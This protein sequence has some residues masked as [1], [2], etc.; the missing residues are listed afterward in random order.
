[1]AG[2]DKAGV[3]VGE[4]G[5]DDDMDMSLAEALRPT[6]RSGSP[7]PLEGMA[8]SGH[9]KYN[10]S[11]SLRS[12]PKVCTVLRLFKAFM[13]AIVTDEPL[14]QDAKCLLSKAHTSHAYT[15]SHADAFPIVIFLELYPSFQRAAWTGATGQI[16]IAYPSSRGF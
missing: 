7:F 10:Y 16:P 15:L 3:D 9:S 11:V 5:L 13:N 6:N 1:V 8:G 4:D 14:R 12:E 2:V